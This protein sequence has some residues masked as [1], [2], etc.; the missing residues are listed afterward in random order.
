[1][2]RD[3]PQQSL[4]SMPFIGE[5]RRSV[6]IAVTRT[7]PPRRYK[8]PEIGSRISEFPLGQF[9]YRKAKGFRWTRK[10][11]RSEKSKGERPR[12]RTE[13]VMGHDK[14][15]EGLTRDRRG[16]RCLVSKRRGQGRGTFLAQKRNVANQ[17]YNKRHAV[18]GL[19]MSSAEMKHNRGT[20]AMTDGRN[21][22]W[23]D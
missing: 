16:K 10:K 19:K 17:E 22:V 6:P 5:S 7:Q 8:S 1:M 2:K 11:L 3:T 23:T 14:Q 12:N 9:A 18:F 20:D 4:L 15:V 13:G 21:N